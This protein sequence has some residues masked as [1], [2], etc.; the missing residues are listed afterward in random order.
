MAGRLKA[1]DMAVNPIKHGSAGSII[2][3]HGDYAAAG[4]PVINTQEAEEYRHL[5]EEYDA[6]FNCGNGNAP[7]IAEK[8]MKLCQDPRLRVTMGRNSRRLAEEKFNRRVT[9]SEI[10]QLIGRGE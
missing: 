6:G 4:L 5:L 8:L 2:N 9:Y 10:I 3:K 1:C 7:D